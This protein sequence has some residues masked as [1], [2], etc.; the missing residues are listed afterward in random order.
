MKSPETR[1]L[2]AAPSRKS[3]GHL[4]VSHGLRHLQK[5]AAKLRRTTI[6]QGHIQQ[7]PLTPFQK[8]NQVKVDTDSYYGELLSDV[9]SAINQVIK[10]QKG[11]RNISLR[12]RKS[13]QE[14][15]SVFFTHTHKI[16]KI[17]FRIHTLVETIN[18]GLWVLMFR[19]CLLKV[20]LREVLRQHP[21][22]MVKTRLRLENL[23]ADLRRERIVTRR[24]QEEYVS[25]LRAFKKAVDQLREE[26]DFY[27]TLVEATQDATALARAE[28][29]CEFLRKEKADLV[30]K[31]KVLQ[32]RVVVISAERDHYFGE[33]GTLEKTCK[34]QASSLEAL[35]AERATLLDEITKLS[36]KLSKYESTSTS[37][38]R[39]RSSDSSL[40]S[41]PPPPL[42]R[43][44]DVPPSLPRDDNIELPPLQTEFFK[45]KQGSSGANGRSSASTMEMQ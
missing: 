28:A 26:R 30:Q 6:G 20:T 38:P 35:E 36:A 18:D 42:P 27:K 11:W 39:R 37:T 32:E 45:E 44:D 8:F 14:I 23:E 3:N 22:S 21:I 5:R 31:A 9:R 1:P 29:E 43:D 33:C 40:D 41:L 34:T 10:Q 12:H 19:S 7:K 15:A 4:A 2:P 24:Q 25:N 17:L 13:I 16:T